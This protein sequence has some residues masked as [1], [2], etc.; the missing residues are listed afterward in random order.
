MITFPD[1]AAVCYTCMYKILVK[2]QVY[3]HRQRKYRRGVRLSTGVGCL[4]V[5]V[6]LST[7]VRF[8]GWSTWSC[9]N[10]GVFLSLTAGGRR[11]CCPWRRAAAGVGPAAG[12]YRSRS[13]G[14]RARLAG[15]LP[16]STPRARVY[17]TRHPPPRPI[18][19][20]RLPPTKQTS[21]VRAC[22]M[23]KE[24]ARIAPRTATRPDCFDILLVPYIGHCISN[25]G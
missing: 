24:Q 9:A 22:N 18:L 21:L 15:H 11:E 6:P 17:I 13:V 4:N 14:L 25:L 8:P 10:K 12:R 1:E 19:P 20:R 23:R 7:G 16:T 2:P 3:R 5:S